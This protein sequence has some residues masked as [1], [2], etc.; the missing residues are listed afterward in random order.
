MPLP[1]P[2]PTNY[3]ACCLVHCSQC[4]FHDILKQG[5]I[6]KSNF[7]L[8]YLLSVVAQHV[9]HILAFLPRSRGSTA[10]NY[11]QQMSFPLNL[12]LP[13]V[14]LC[15]ATKI[16]APRLGAMEFDVTPLNL[17]F[18]NVTPW[19]L[20]WLAVTS[21]NLTPSDVRPLSLTPPEMML[22]NFKQ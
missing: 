22:S 21:L 11:L 7:N 10:S 19:N 6:N 8:C 20:T 15:N 9:H 13:G 4:D 14:T 18:P 3:K 2:P 17:T 12:T 16:D 5:N 1:S